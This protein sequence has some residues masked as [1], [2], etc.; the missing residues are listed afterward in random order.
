MPAVNP[1][2]TEKY[3]FNGLPAEILKKEDEGTEKYWFNGL[4]GESLIPIAIAVI[5]VKDVIYEG[6]I[7]FPR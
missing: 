4:S 3:W 5:A 7:V 6:I 2:G 1:Q